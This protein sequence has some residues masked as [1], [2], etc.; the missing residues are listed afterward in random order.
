M[1]NTDT[2]NTIQQFVLIP[3]ITALGT[4]LSILMKVGFDLL[5]DKIKDARLKKYINLALDS[6]EVAVNSTNQQF[7]DALKIKGTFSEENYEEAFEITK[8]TAKSLINDQVE[9]LI[10]EAYKDFD[11]WLNAQ[12]YA[13]VRF[14][15]IENKTDTI[16]VNTETTNIDN[17]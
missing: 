14:N 13:Q 17:K 11:T 10:G 8:N 2:L 15:K 1:F 4:G 6:V 9:A 5:V 16:T 12:I 3:V 7:V